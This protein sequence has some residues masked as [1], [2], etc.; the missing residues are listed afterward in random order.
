MDSLLLNVGLPQQVTR[1]QDMG[2]TWRK[3]D[4]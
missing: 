3:A 2:M 4:R 1:E